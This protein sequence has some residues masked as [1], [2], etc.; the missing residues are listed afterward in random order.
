MART[1]YIDSRDM[2][3]ALDTLEEAY[4]AAVNDGDREAANALERVIRAFAK[5]SNV[6]VFEH[7]AD[8]AKQA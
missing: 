7:A 1:A 2:L 3:I 5:N 8:K 4:F 6:C